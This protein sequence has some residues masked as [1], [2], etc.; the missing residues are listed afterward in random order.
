MKTLGEKNNYGGELLALYIFYQT[1]SIKLVNVVS[2]CFGAGFSDPG[3]VKPLA[4]SVG[5][6]ESGVLVFSVLEALSHLY[7]KVFKILKNQ[8][9]VCV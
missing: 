9:T 8:L 1:Y 2:R 4:F 6:H 3:E 5:D 7:V